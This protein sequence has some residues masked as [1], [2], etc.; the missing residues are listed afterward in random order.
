MANFKIKSVFVQKTESSINPDEALKG[1]KHL[2]KLKNVEKCM[3][4]KSAQEKYQEYKSMLLKRHLLFKSE[5]SEQ[6]KIYEIFQP[7]A[8]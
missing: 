7:T 8:L 5:Y 1:L 6:E 3:K 4:S 2:E